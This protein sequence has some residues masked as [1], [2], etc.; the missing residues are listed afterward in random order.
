[1]N[2]FLVQIYSETTPTQPMMTSSHI[3]THT[4]DVQPTKNN[5]VNSADV[6]IATISDKPNAP[7]HEDSNRPEDQRYERKRK[8]RKE[9]E[10]LK[11]KRKES[12]HKKNSE[13]DN[14]IS[15]ILKERHITGKLEITRST[16]Y[17]YFI[18]LVYPTTRFSDIGGCTT[19]LLVSMASFITIFVCIIGGV[20][21][22]VA[23]SS[24]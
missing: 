19:T 6:T 10:K 18:D 2:D 17:I 1:M 12:D 9:K 7:I 21:S 5:S 16:Y 3:L 11:K 20:S 22:F 24:S 13:V 8:G 4:E 15:D 23:F 14:A